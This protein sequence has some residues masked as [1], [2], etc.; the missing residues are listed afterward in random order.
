MVRPTLHDSS[1]P[2]IA[3]QLPTA[4]SLSKVFL[5]TSTIDPF[6][7]RDPA[8]RNVSIVTVG[9]PEPFNSG[10]AHR[11]RFLP[12]GRKSRSC[13]GTLATLGWA[14]KPR[15]TN[16]CATPR[17]TTESRLSGHDACGQTIAR[18]QAFSTQNTFVVVA[19]RSGRFPVKPLQRGIGHGAGTAAT[20][21]AKSAVMLPAIRVANFR[22]HSAQ[23]I[24]QALRP[25]LCQN[26]GTAEHWSCNRPTRKTASR[27]QY[28]SHAGR[29]RRHV[30]L[31]ADLGSL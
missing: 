25:V 8:K 19:S 14:L 2:G 9:R 10:P 6:W 30:P 5:P 15:L 28:G 4:E 27:L 24:G 31:P 1:F 20:I 12:R 7:A 22:A 29:S 21:S 18:K 26:A 3:V 17:C 23:A 13:C 16:A 11:A